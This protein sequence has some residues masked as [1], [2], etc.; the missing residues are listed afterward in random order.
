[1]TLRE[2]LDQFYNKYNIPAEGG[3]NDKTFVVPLPLFSLTLPNFSW[4]K[5]MLYVH[6][7]EHILNE[8]DT[9]WK[10]EIFIASWEISTGFLKNFP[11]LIFPLWTMGWGLWVNPSTVL[12]AFRKGHADRGIAR[13]PIEKEILLDYNLSQLQQ[14]TLNK[15]SGRSA[16][17]FY[18][19]L[20]GWGLISQLV[21]F[22]PIIALIGFLS[23][24]L[25]FLS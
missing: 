3:V 4:R 21:F 25:K 15:R 24:F 11:V 2:Q 7:L 1:M 22:S 14:L 16:S 17:F 19:K 10:G 13:L 6:D 8:Q 20:A 18:L 9:S 23:I 5:R 12:H